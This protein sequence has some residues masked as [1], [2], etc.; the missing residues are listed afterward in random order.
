[1]PGAKKITF[2]ADRCEVCPNFVVGV[3]GSFDSLLTS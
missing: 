1:M 2:S 3:I